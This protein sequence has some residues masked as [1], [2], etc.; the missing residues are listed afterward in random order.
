MKY[1]VQLL[2][3]TTLTPIPSYAEENESTQI[4][5]NSSPV[6]G[7]SAELRELLSR[8]M[9]ELQNGMIAITPL[10]ISGNWAEIE[11]IADK[12]ENSY[13]FKQNLSKLQKH[14]LHSKLPASFLELDQHFH[15]LAGMLKHVAK[16]EKIELI[17]FYTWKLNESC[18]NCHTK[19]ATHKFPSLAPKNH[20]RH[21]H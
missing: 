7:L 1:L 14:E 2:L 9:L 6:S 11:Q 18:I 17:G 21:D 5:V 8:E 15:Y 13:V 20:N 3:I 4:Q 16:M 10:Y 12:M 19:F